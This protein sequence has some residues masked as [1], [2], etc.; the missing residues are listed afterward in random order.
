MRFILNRLEDIIAAVV[1][2]GIGLFIVIEA[3][4]YRMGTLT[5]MGPGY[6]PAILGW[7]MIAL[8][9]LILATAQQSDMPSRPGRDQLRGMLFVAAAF[10]AFALTIERFGMMP[11]VTLSVLLASL[12]NERTHPLVALLLGIGTAT[13]CTLIFRVGLGL[14][15]EAF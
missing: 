6:F 8:G 14:Q 10:G 12:A 1:T 2:A 5:S 3:G 9:A 11:S 4:S 13:A 15:I 7:T